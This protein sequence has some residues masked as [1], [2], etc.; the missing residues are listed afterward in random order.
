VC[1]KRSSTPLVRS[2]NP[3]ARRHLVDDGPHE[4]VPEA[5][6]ARDVGAAQE[7]RAQELVERLS[8]GPVIGTGGGRSELRLE[9]VS[10]H[11]GAFEQAPRGLRQQRQLLRERRGDRRRNVDAR[12]SHVTPGAVHG[13]ATLR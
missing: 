2:Q 3:A 9:R 4:R 1:R 11:G 12:E 7:I 10:G 13:P 5:K 8:G 6:A